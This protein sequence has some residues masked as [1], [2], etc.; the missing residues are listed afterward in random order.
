[1][2]EDIA[3]D[4]LRPDHV[5]ASDADWFTLSTFA[6]TFDG[7]EQSGGFERC[8]DLANA[9]LERF[10]TTGEV[11][12]DLN[13]LRSCLFFEQRR[14]RHFGEEP[15]DRDMRYI[16]ALVEAIRRHVEGGATLAG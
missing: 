10:N 4:E 16:R 12:D 6:L 1:M 3:N 7:Y 11:S 13:V 9:T 14:W 5:P 8:G 2:T 15:G